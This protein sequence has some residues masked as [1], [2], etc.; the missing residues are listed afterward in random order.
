M[1]SPP[2]NGE[3]PED[4]VL[5]L[6]GH[7]ASEVAGRYERAVV[8]GADTIVT[9]DG[10]VFGKPD[11]ETAAVQMLARLRGK[12]HRVITGVTAL[13]VESGRSAAAAVGTGVTMRWYSE[14]EIEAYVASGDALDKAGAYAVQDDVFNPGAPR[15]AA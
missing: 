10:Q 6:S 1:E 2:R 11:S 9:L 15:D 5:R 3:S 12:T 8:L 4:Y 7:K 13:D 14:E